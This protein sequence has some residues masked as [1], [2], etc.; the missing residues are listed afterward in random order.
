MVGLTEVAVEYSSP[1]VKGRKIWGELI[2]LDKLW[3]AGANAA[4]KVTFS[5]DVTV[6]DKPVPAGSYRC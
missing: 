2:P 6:G 5:K 1:A 3:R 4:T